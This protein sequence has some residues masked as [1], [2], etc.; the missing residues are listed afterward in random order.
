M[1]RSAIVVTVIVLLEMF[2]SARVRAQ[3]VHREAEGDIPS[4]YS[5]DLLKRSTLT[6]DWAGSAT[7]WLRRA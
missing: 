5:G 4:N 3:D 7:S 1:K 2:L 6:G